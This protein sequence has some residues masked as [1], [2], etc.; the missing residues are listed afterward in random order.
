MCSVLDYGIASV[1]TQGL[2][3]CFAEVLF[4]QLYFTLHPLPVIAILLSNI[5]ILV[6]CT[7]N[8]DFKLNPV[9]QIDKNECMKR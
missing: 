8:I 4:L 7:S 6:P 5:D 1:L 3:T 2:L 9:T